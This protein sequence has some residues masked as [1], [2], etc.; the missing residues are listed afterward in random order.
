MY[1]IKIFAA[2]GERMTAV[3][4]KQGAFT[5]GNDGSPLGH[6]QNG[7][8]YRK[9]QLIPRK[10]AAL[11]GKAV[12][13]VS[14]SSPE[15]AVA[16]T[17]ASLGELFS[18][19]EGRRGAL[20]HGGESP[21]PLPRQVLALAD[22]KV[23]G[24]AVGFYHTAV[25]TKAGELFTFGDASWGDLGH[26]G[27]INSESV[28]KLVEALAGEKVAGAT[29]GPCFTLAW[30]EEGELFT[31]GDGREGQLGHGALP[32][33]KS[34]C[35]EDVP[36]LVEALQGKKV[37]GASAG[38]CHTVAWT[39]E[40]ELFTCGNGDCGQLGHGELNHE[41]VPRL[42]DTLVGKKVVSAAAA[43]AH[44]VVT[45]ETG[46]VFSFGHGGY[47]QLGH[48]GTE[49]ERV[50]RLV[51]ALVGNKVVGV[52]AG[53]T[54]TFHY[55]PGGTAHTAVWTEEGEIFTFGQGSS[56]QLGHGGHASEYVPRRVQYSELCE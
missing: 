12:V 36:R 16:W 14:I 7:S 54:S 40:G 2:A 37:V 18:F 5:F 9:T 53:G 48:G 26:G 55:P 34:Q 38:D 11:Q 41:L 27:E 15:H 1:R 31:F 3:C 17:D 32:A 25:W 49:N 44:T 6:L 39:E 23:A 28:P 35:V 19:G 24:A 47:G 13:G 50:P 42:V 45:T 22:E 52:V 8:G 33:L 46:E 43:D 4:T 10:V 29:T 21:E 56:G 20:G 30:T 51:E